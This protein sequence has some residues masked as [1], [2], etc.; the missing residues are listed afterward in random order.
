L[1]FTAVS[2]ITLLDEVTL[3]AIVGHG[4]QNHYGISA[5]LFKAVANHQ[6]NVILSGSGA[7]DLVSYLVI[8]EK[9]KSKCVKAVYQ[10]FIES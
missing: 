10:A 3:V 5:T 7:S 6:I 8:A 2:E 1:G 9:D 4:M